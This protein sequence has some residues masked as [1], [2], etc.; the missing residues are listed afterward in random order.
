VNPL[1]GEFAVPLMSCLSG[2]PHL[3]KSCNDG[4]EQRR[5][6][7]ATAGQ[8]RKGSDALTGPA[9]RV[10]DEEVASDTKDQRND[11]SFT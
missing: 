1:T 4:A 2:P 9:R 10:R 3:C 8:V 5:S 11:A 6:R 7:Q